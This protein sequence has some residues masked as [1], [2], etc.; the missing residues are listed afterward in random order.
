MSLIW[1]E[2]YTYGDHSYT[3]GSCDPSLVYNGYCT[4]GDIYIPAAPPPIQNCNF[5]DI[6]CQ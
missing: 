5:G 3:P 6:G 2:W 4:S 1:Y